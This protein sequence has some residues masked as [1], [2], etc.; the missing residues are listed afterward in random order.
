MYADYYSYAVD[1]GHRLAR[2]AS[3]MLDDESGDSF[4][5]EM[6]E[7]G[8]R[9][10]PS[11]HKSLHITPRTNISSSDRHNSDYAMAPPSSRSTYPYRPSVRVMPQM[12]ALVVAK[13]FIG[14]PARFV[15]FYFFSSCVFNGVISKNPY[16]FDVVSPMYTHAMPDRE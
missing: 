11:H 12:D 15:L 13:Y 10:K 4:D 6:L 5:A 2:R 14:T 9:S 3:G 1:D 16:I 8:Q 7:G